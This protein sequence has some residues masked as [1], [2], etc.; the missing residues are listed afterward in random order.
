[1]T[2]FLNVNALSGPLRPRPGAKLISHC[3]PAYSQLAV[4]TST[5]TRGISSTIRR[6][7]G[8]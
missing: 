2:P 1:L 4:I 5:P 8:T 6:I 3:D 7:V